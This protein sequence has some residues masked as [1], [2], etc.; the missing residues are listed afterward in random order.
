MNLAKQMENVLR[1]QIKLID[2]IYA[3]QRNVYNQVLKR[4]WDK[5]KKSMEDLD[6]LS[7]KFAT[8]D[9][10]LVALM[11]EKNSVSKQG[12]ENK[13]SLNE[14]LDKTIAGFS[15]P[16]KAKIE[17]L[18]KT[19]KEKVCLSKIENDAFNAYID[20]A[21]SLVSGIFEVLAQNRSGD[22]YTCTGAKSDGDISNVLVNRVY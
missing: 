15:V 14:T 12:L 22:T 10:K 4:D 11:N 2:E 21:R 19:L 20:H 7:E 16:E 18:Y 3:I 8:A 1:L 17:N 6:V 9:S 13:I 5:S